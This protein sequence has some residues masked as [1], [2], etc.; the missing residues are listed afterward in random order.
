MRDGRKERRRQIPEIRKPTARVTSCN[1]RQ[2]IDNAMC[3]RQI[4]LEVMKAYGLHHLGE[5]EGADG[6]D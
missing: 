2:A 1:I 6:C 4:S 5:S 3:V